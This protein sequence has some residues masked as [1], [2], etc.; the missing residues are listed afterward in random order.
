MY[1]L[2][3]IP[4]SHACRSAILMLEHKGVPYRRVDIV[5]LLHPLASRLLGFDAGGETRT[6]GARRTLPI[7]FGDLLGTVPGLA[8]DGQRVATN[9]QIARFLDDRHPEPSLFPADPGERRAVE[10]AERWANGT[11]QMAARRIALGWPVRDPAGA[12]RSTADGRMG[13]LLYRRE[14]ARRL[15]IPQ[16][17]RRG[18]AVDASAERELLAG[19]P[20]MLDRIDAWIAGGILGGAQLNAADFMVAPSLAL[21]LYRPDLMPRF[22]GRPA[23]E[24]VDR[25]LPEPAR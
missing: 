17:G 20:A 1:T 9:R 22:E 7:R 21:M 15:I 13:F 23:L 19:L 12:A 11:L 10:E 25:L 8:S 18:F 5:T 16:I 6:A 24:L 2:Y 14:L 3:V 4:G